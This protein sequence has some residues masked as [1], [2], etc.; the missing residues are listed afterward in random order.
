MNATT[1][2]TAPKGLRGW[3]ADPPRSGL[4]RTIVPWGI[5]TSAPLG[6]R[7]LLVAVSWPS[8]ASCSS[9]TTPTNGAL[10]LVLGTLNLGGG[11]WY[12]TMARSAP[13]RA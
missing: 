1:G 8:S 10:F 3:W 5:A 2:N 11:Y 6:S 13:P 7:A 4:A 12:L 9:P